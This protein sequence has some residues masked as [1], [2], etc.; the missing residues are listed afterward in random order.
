MVGLF[1][2]EGA[3]TLAS[4]IAPRKN[5]PNFFLLFILELKGKSRLP[6]PPLTFLKKTV[7][8][9]ESKGSMTNKTGCFTYHSR[10]YR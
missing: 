6:P 10:G 7:G 9:L 3:P 5:P 2:G 8:I 4:E 1:Y